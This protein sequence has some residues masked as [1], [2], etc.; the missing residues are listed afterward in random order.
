MRQASKTLFGSKTQNKYSGKRRRA[1][2]VA[3]SHTPSSEYVHGHTDGEKGAPM[4]KLR[5][6][7]RYHGGPNDERMAFMESHSPLY[8]KDLAVSAEQVSIFLT[9]GKLRSLQF[10]E[11]AANSSQTIPSFHSSSPPLMILNYPSSIVCPLQT[12]F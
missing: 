2:V 9:A 7:Q 1:R 10:L 12:L 11:S 3:N 5:T 6:L 4:Q 8:E